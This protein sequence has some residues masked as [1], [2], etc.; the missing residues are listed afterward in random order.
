MGKNDLKKK[1]LHAHLDPNAKQGAVNAILSLQR[2]NDIIAMLLEGKEA[3]EVRGYLCAKYN[4]TAGFANIL[5]S[6]ARKEIKKRQ[7]YEIG[8]M[9]AMHIHRYEQIYKELYQ[10]KAQVAAMDALRAKEKLLGFHKEGFH[11]KVTKGEIQAVQLQTV[12]S[13]YDVMKLD[14]QQTQ[15]FEYLLNKARRKRDPEGTTDATIV[16]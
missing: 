6:S 12:D 9:I 5:I 16:G 2:R 7:N 11:M 14:S 13:E 10:M 3:K 1:F 8:S 4:I 15:R